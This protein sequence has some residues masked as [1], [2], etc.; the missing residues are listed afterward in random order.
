METEVFVWM[1]CF[2]FRCVNK[3]SSSLTAACFRGPEPN[4][5]VS[6]AFVWMC[7]NPV[8]STVPPIIKEFTFGF[9]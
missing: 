1:K 4:A 7:M 5:A 8:S 9:E 3:A 6:V 2:E